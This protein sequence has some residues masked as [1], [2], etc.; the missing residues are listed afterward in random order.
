MIEIAELIIELR[1][2]EQ[3]QKMN[4]KLNKILFALAVVSLAGCATTV[5]ERVVV[6]EQPPQVIVRQMPAPITEVID[7]QPGP[8]YAW[9]QGH[10]AWHGNAWVWQRGHWY[11]GA[12]RPMP[13]L[14]V[15]QMYAAPSP[16]H[17]WV[18]GH[19]HWRGNDWAWEKGRWVE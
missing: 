3:G 14:I 2:K 7:V 18:P 5:R 16:R 12:V 13:A 6:R 17:Y 19:W 4:H 8:G 11:Q 1:N 15:E 10:W 9:V